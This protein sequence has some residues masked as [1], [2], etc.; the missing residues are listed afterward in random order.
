[1]AR[2]GIESLRV[3]LRAPDGSYAGAFA[4]QAGLSRAA[5]GFRVLRVERFGEALPRSL[6]AAAVDALTEVAQREHRVLRLTVEVFSRDRETRSRL[7]E[8]LAGAGFVRA[9]T[10]LNWSTTLVLDL[11]PTETELFASFS[12]S[13]R[14]GIRSVQQHPLQVR[15]VD[16]CRLG[17]RLEALSRETRVRT[18]GRYEALW[19]WAGV[20]ELSRRVP[21]AARL[22]GLF[23]TDREGPDALL[24]FSWAW[25]NGRSA[26]YFAGASS[27]PSD[28]GRL[29]IGYPLMWDLI[30]WAKRAGATWFDFGGVTAGTT[31]SGDPLGGIS[32][33]KRLFAKETAEVAEDWVL[34]PRKVVARLAKLVSTSAAWLSCLAPGSAW[35]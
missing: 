14:R 27:R 30:T 20:I 35:L 22:V 15:V 26:S 13:A 10:A 12:A 17:D 6:W 1:L 4:I 34:E 18:G 7:G 5:P 9:P 31:G 25:W 28:L 3:L 11:Q 16:D 33:F 19:D 21:D 24:G 29:H 32:D 2:K 8:L 23:R